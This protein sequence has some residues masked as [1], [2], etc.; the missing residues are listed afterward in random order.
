MNWQQ[1]RW[2]YG[3]ASTVTRN[4]KSTCWESD[5]TVNRVF[6]KRIKWQ[7]AHFRCPEAV[8]SCETEG[9]EDGERGRNRTYNLLLKSYVFRCGCRIN[10]CSH[11][12]N[13][14]IKRPAWTAS[15]NVDKVGEIERY[16][17]AKDTNNIRRTL[18]L[19]LPIRTLY[20]CTIRPL[21][22]I[23]SPQCPVVE[24]AGGLTLLYEISRVKN[25]VVGLKQFCVS[26]QRVPGVSRNARAESS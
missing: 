22:L 23:T 20:R 5:K 21:E 16:L 18:L 12:N 24:V 25:S 4:C 6:A 14:M 26:L 10:N 17:I 3:H 13:L 19:A 2:T 7:K 11:D 1:Y 9:D 15:E 8:K